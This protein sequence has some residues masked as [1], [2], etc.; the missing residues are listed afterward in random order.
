[1]RDERPPEGCCLAH[2]H[3]TGGTI[4]RGKARP[5]RGRDS[6]QTLVAVRRGGGWRFAAFHNGRVRPMSGGFAAVIF[7]VL[8]DGLWKAL[9]PKGGNT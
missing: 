6:I 9:G 1:M 3:A 8:T 5:S 7:W 2:V 4:M